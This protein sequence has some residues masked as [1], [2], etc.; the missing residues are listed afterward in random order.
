[1]ELIFFFSS[2]KFRFVWVRHELRK[3]HFYLINRRTHGPR[4]VPHIL[5]CFTALIQIYS[6]S[7]NVFFQEIVAAAFFFIHDSTKLILFNKNNQN[8]TNRKKKMEKKFERQAN[9]WAFWVKSLKWNMLIVCLLRLSRLQ[10][11]EKSERAPQFTKVVVAPSYFIQ[12]IWVHRTCILLLLF[13]FARCCK[14]PQFSPQSTWFDSIILPFVYE[15]VCS[16]KLIGRMRIRLNSTQ[17]W[18]SF[19]KHFE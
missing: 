13:Y 7:N 4:L 8:E 18:P 12:H 19:H 3:E 9:V 2:S 14:M 1:M 10:F 16:L 17:N 6:V 11:P 15:N 5:W